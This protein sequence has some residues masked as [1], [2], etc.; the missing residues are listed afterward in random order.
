MGVLN[1]GINEVIATTATNAAP[2]GIRFVNGEFSMNLFTGSHTHNNVARD[3]WIVA[4]LVFDPVLYV[5]TAFGDL[6]PEAFCEIMVKGRRMVR[7]ANSEAWA[8]FSVTPGKVA[9]GVYH[10]DLALEQEFSESSRPRPINRGFNSIIDAT[11]HA[12]RYNMNHSPELKRLIE[13]HAGIVRKCGGKRDHE[14]LALLL[15]ILQL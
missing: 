10:A 13:Y 7:L 4:N 15:E 14:A 12:T 8:A 5:Q 11:V 2:M 3:G 9:A 1:E 6:G